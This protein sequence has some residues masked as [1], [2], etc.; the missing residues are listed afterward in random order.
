MG[1]DVNSND[2]RTSKRSLA[3][4]FVAVVLLMP[5]ASL[6]ATPA[7]HSQIALDLPVNIAANSAELDDRQGTGVYQG[8]VVVTRGNMTLWA[9]RITLYA[10]D[11]RPERLVAEGQPVRVE[12]PDPEQQPRTAT[13]QRMEYHFATQILT[14]IG[15]A[16]VT[17][18]TEDARGEKISYDLTR[19]IIRA[20][21]SPG[22][23]VQITIQPRPE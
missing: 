21:S 16:R 22:Q 4:L 11:R 13:A 2:R 12:M 17:T 20:E 5:L 19:D 14:L 1:V 10:P 3:C 23:R 6:A 18:N 15:E 7:A 8:D 9:D